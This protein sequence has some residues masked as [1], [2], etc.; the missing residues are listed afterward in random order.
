[1]LET[2]GLMA[3]GLQVREETSTAPVRVTVVL[4]VAPF[5]VA[6]TVTFWFWVILPALAVKVE[7]VAPAATVT[8]AGVV[9]SEELSDSATLL[10]D[11]GAA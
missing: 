2:L 3:L 4:C 11:E 7:D 6:L 10:P 1:M 9:S 5:K 8:E